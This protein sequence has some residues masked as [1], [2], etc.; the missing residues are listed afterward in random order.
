VQ[1]E[2]RSGL[3]CV[4]T[5]DLKVR[6]DA[7]VRDNG[8]FTTDELHEVLPQASRSVL[9]EIVTVQLRYRKNGWQLMKK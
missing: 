6:V 5:G 8:R 9:Y 3:P 4:I 1:Y 2:A 7:H